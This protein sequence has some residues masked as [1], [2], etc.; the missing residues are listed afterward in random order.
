[1]RLKEARYPTREEL[2]AVAPNHPVAFR[3]GPDA[4]LNR[5][6]LEKCGFDRNFEVKDGGPGYLEKDANGEPN[7]LARNLGRYIKIE[8]K[9]RR[10][11][12]EDHLRRL[13]ELFH[14]YHQ[15]GFTAIADRG[16]TVESI[17]RYEKLRATG[18][19]TV[20]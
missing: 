13:Q 2:D 12:E 14:D 10:P 7:G 20:R 3:T 5:L 8:S 17:Q 18:G 9:G 1:T 16:A 15:I 19:L 4:M 11:S 6:A